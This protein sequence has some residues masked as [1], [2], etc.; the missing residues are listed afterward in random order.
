[1]RA[2][3]RRG[4]RVEQ[5]ETALCQRVCFHLV[6]DH[7]AEVVVS[8]EHGDLS[9]FGRRV[10]FTE[11][12]I[13]QLGRRRLQELLRHQTCNHK[14]TE[15]DIYYVILDVIYPLPYWDIIQNMLFRGK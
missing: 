11:T 13:R 15:Q 3:V 1:M 7:R 10:E 9:L 12:V 2:G 4:L 5:S 8:K 14:P 6:F